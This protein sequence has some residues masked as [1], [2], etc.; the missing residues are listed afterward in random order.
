[1]F[2]KHIEKQVYRVFWK[3]CFVWRE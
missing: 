3:A 2:F 1:M